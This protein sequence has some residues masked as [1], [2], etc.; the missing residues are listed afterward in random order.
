[1]W[2]YEWAGN[3][4]DHFHGPI[5][6]A[7]VS[8]PTLGDGV[9]AFLRY[10]PSRI[11]YMHLHGRQEGTLFYAELSPL[12]D[13]GAVKPILV[14]TPIVLLQKH[15]ENVYGVDL[16]QAALELD[17]PETAHAERCR[18][19]FPFPVRFS[20][21]RNALVIPAAWRIL[22]NLGHVESTWV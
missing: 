18:A 2:Y 5:S 16:A 10:F 12:I 1:A 4:A 9:D 7:L 11:P 8:A 21:G 13:L 20:A 6:I 15:L 19:Y 22:R 3:L 14:E 17:Y